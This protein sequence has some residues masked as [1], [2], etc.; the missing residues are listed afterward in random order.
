MQKHTHSGA[1][2]PAL[3]SAPLATGLGATLLGLI[4]AY[5]VVYTPIAG[6]ISL[7]FL[8]G[9]AIGLF[10]LVAMSAQWFKCRAPWFMSAVGLFAGAVALYTSWAFFEYALVSRYDDTS[11]L[12]MLDFLTNPAAV[13]ALMVEINADGWYTISS[14]TPSGAVLWFFWGIE[15]LVILA[16]G[17]LAGMFALTD[18]VFCERC[19]TWADDVEPK[20]RVELP[21]DEHAVQQDNVDWMTGLAALPEGAYPVMRGQLKSC[22]TCENTTPLKLEVVT[23]EL[24]K[25]GN[26]SETTAELIPTSATST[27]EHGKLVGL[28]ARVPPAPSPAVAD[29]AEP[30]R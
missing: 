22:P 5:V 23:A 12:T 28:A 17:G 11:T 29:E 16:A 2:G 10:M 21:A 7:L 3:I 4:Y 1:I 24:D 26:V 30:P 18:E 13:W 14:A 6:Y 15:A 27:F 20:L 9:F 8:A 25:D 19:N